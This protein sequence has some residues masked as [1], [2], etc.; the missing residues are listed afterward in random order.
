[1]FLQIAVSLFSVPFF[2]Q[3]PVGHCPS[4]HRPMAPPFQQEHPARSCASA[5]GITRP[6]VAVGLITVPLS[7]P[8]KKIIQTDFVS[9]II[10]PEHILQNDPSSFKTKQIKKKEKTSVFIRYLT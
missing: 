6:E 7:R 9:L 5:L 1:M 4:T 10:I 8:L 3:P 2:Q